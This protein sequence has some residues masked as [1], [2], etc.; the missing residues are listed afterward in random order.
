MA[1]RLTY[2]V[3]TL[4]RA[5]VEVSR[6]CVDWEFQHNRPVDARKVGYGVPSPVTKD[7]AGKEYLCELVDTHYN[8]ARDELIFV[9]KPT[10]AVDDL[11]DHMARLKTIPDQD[12]ME[13][14]QKYA[15]EQSDATD[16][17]TTTEPAGG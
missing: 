14:P 13:A 6:A 15:G 17:H 4:P 8:A 5:T 11:P 9:W 7:N 10:L 2:L 1:W 16:V 3:T 12:P